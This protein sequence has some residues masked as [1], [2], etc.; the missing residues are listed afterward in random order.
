MHKSRFIAIEG[1]DGSGKSTQIR[2]L[3]EYLLKQG[4]DVKFVHFPRLNQGFF[5]ELIAKFL[6]GELGEVNNVDPHMVALL[7]AEDRREYAPMIAKWLQEGA[8]VLVDRYVYSN[9]SYQCAKISDPASKI[10]LKQW[11]LKLEY[12]LNLIPKPDFSLYLDVPFD[13][14][15]KLLTQKREGLDRIYL[16]GKKDIHEDSLGLQIA[17][18]AEY[19]SLVKSTMDLQRVIC[20]NEDGGMKSIEEIHKYIL[21]LLQL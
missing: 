19:E 17:V 10:A 12:E 2:L 21:S 9:I 6:R 20:F 18:K 7:F 8:T 11:I 14:T 5:G 13:F 1:A 3:S 15:K 16:H 4:K